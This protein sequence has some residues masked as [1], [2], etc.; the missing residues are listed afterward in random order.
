MKKF[1]TLVALT[2][3]AGCNP[4]EMVEPTPPAPTTGTVV[5][6]VT[7]SVVAGIACMIGSG[8]T[9]TQIVPMQPYTASVGTFTIRCNAPGHEEGIDPVV[10]V[11]AGRTTPAKVNM[12]KQV[13]TPP[14]P[15]TATG[16]ITSNIYPTRA[17]SVWTYS[18]TGGRTTALVNKDLPYNVTLP[19][20]SGLR[21]YW[22]SASGHYPEPVSVVPMVGHAINEKAVMRQVPPPSPTPPTTESVLIASSPSQVNVVV[23]AIQLDGTWKKV[24]TTRSDTVVN[25][26]EGHYKANFAGPDGYLDGVAYTD[27]KPGDPALP[28]V[29]VLKKR[30]VTP[31]VITTGRLMAACDIHT[32]ADISTWATKQLLFSGTTNYEVEIEAG[33]YIVTFVPPAGYTSKPVVVAVNAEQRSV[34]NCNLKKDEVAPPPPPPPPPPTGGTL[35]IRADR[36]NMECEVRLNGG[37]I[38]VFITDV[39]FNQ[40]PPGKYTSRCV[41]PGSND[42]Q[43]DARATLVAGGTAILYAEMAKV[44][45]SP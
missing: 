10:I 41:K 20:D 45:G 40:M 15:T 36:P 11:E 12:V 17:E 7:P 38:G 1:A 13:V 34:A 8:T 39:T 26:T 16:W 37:V 27:V 4:A 33:F 6:G 35:H 43:G 30:S 19:A 25:L 14:A 9:S 29:A 44:P 24:L 32:H 2:V 31:V 42:L 22:I 23:S 5:L 3:L 18:K 21:I 28:L